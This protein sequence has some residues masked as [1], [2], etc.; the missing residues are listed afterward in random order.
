MI[1]LN[2]VEEDV[3]TEASETKP[4]PQVKRLCELQ[5]RLKDDPSELLKTGFLCRGAALLLAGPTGVGKS[6]LAMQF[7]IAWAIGQPVFGI[8]PTRPLK[9]LLVQAENDEGDL[10]EMKQGVLAGLNLTPAQ[11]KAA[12][13]NV[14]TIQEDRRTSLTFC[15]EVLV[16]LLKEHK[17]DLL[18]IDPMFAYIGGNASGQEHVTPFLRN[19][20][21]PL[22][23]EAQC[24]LVAV[25]HTNKPPTGKEKSSWAGSDLAYVGS[26]SIEWA[27][28]S[29]AVLALRSLGSHDVYELIAAKRGARLGWLNDDGSRSFARTIAHWREPGVICWRD[30]EPNEAGK[31]GRPKSNDAD[32]LLALL[33][34]AGLSTSE[35]KAKAASED[36]ISK[37]TFY[38]LKKELEKAKRIHK[39]STSDHW[40][41]ITKKP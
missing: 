28:W 15:D 29:R 20:L 13:S 4:S 38:R 5:P 11:R 31:T 2:R 24:G 3:G 1:D 37:S 41:P 30:A 9:S 32:E 8:E 35:W 12:E 40:Q 19:M 39:S 34:R 21:N 33:P 23:R 10:F 7:K 17:P 25:H 18:W 16:P 22:I 14:I 6:A 26:G 27:N 36:G